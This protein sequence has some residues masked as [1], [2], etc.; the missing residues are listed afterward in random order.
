MP[1]A[2][3]N[4]PK[5]V[6]LT[7]LSTALSGV[8]TGEW[9]FSCLVETGG[10]RILFDTGN[11]PETV[12]NNVREM[13]VDLATVPTVVLSHHHADHTGGLVTLR[14]DVMKRDSKAL[15]MAHG[16]E[17]ILTRRQPANGF[18]LVKGEYE[19]TGARLRVI[20]KPMQIFP[21]VWL[22]GPV[23]RVHNERNWSGNSL[24]RPDDR[25]EE[26]TIPEDQSLV[27][28]TDQGLIILSGCGHAGIVNI[29]TYA[30]KIVRDTSIYAMAGGFHLF[31]ANVR[32]LEWTAGQLAPLRINYFLAAHCTGIESTV[33]LREL[34]GIPPERM[35]VAQVGS[36]FEAG[37]GIQPLP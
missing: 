20:D 15:A 32:Q 25:S 9:G 18:T 21:N 17:G 35:T 19:S 2:A 30:R 36:R 24:L 31:Q 37:I 27:I 12:L 34:L 16:A 14:R 22:T 6:K 3:Q 26:D 23:P 10:Q 8:Y 1:L 5:T 4:R 29:A 33:K 13:K 28:D 7:V 11:R